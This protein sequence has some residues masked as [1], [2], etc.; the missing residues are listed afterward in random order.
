MNPTISE[1]SRPFLLEGFMVVLVVRME[2]KPD[3]LDALISL[4]TWNATESRKETGNVRFDL[5]RSSEHPTRLALYEVYRDEEALRVHRA[6]PHFARWSQEVGPLLV[7]PRI[8]EKYVNVMP[9]PWR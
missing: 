9:E 4:A 8:G 6:T 7:A 1:R 2:A 3:K 5:L